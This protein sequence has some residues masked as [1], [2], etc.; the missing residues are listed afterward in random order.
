MKT[1]GKFEQKCA[2]KKQEKH[3]CREAYQL[4]QYISSQPL[5]IQKIP[6]AFVAV[7]KMPQSKQGGREGGDFVDF[8]R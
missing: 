8:R 3:I 7:Y 4:S 5:A 1:K 2:K 6:E